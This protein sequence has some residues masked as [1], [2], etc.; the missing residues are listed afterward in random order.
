M[1]LCC[2]KMNSFPIRTA[3]IGFVVI[4]LLV[5]SSIAS[6][7][8]GIAQRRHPALLAA[9][10]TPIA[11]SRNN[12]YTAWPNNDTG[13]L[14]VFFAKSN[15][16]GNTFSKTMIISSPN[17]GNVS[18]ENVNIAASEN[19]VYV[20]WW[21]NKTGKFEPVF[22][23]SNDNGDTFGKIIKLNSTAGGISR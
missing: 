14:N 22:R 8:T 12:V 5:V 9:A 11:V 1:K 7:P 20:S 15:D 19:N 21:T 3:A 2:R 16:Y 13:R 6:L 18:H 10:D 17:P 23:A 4:S